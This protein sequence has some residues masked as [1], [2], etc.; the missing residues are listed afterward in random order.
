VSIAGNNGAEIWMLPFPGGAKAR[1]KPH[2]VLPS[3]LSS[4][5]PAIS[6]M[7]DNRH[8]VLSFAAPSRA[9]QLWMSDTAGGSVV[10][11]TSG[12]SPVSHPAV[13]P[14]GMKIACE[15]IMGNSDI[16]QLPVDGGM[17][18]PLLA[19]GSDESAAVWSRQAR[20]AAPQFAYVTSRNGRPE[21]W[22]RS[23]QEGW[24]RPVVTQQDFQDD[25][26]GF[27]SLAL[28]PDGER[29]AYMRTSN[30]RLATI[31][32]SPAG[33]GQPLQ[34]SSNDEFA[35]GPTWSPDGDWIAYSSSKRG[36][37]KLAAG[38]GQAPTQI[39]P[40][41][42]MYAAQSS[43]D[44][45]WI[46]CP[47][48]G[49]TSLISPDGKTSRTV[50][51]R[52]AMVTWSRDS[53]TLYT[54]GQDDKQKWLLTSIPVS[55]GTEKTIAEMGPENSFWAD[56]NNSSMISLSPD[57]KSIAATNTQSKSDVWLLEGFP[58]PGSWLRRLFWL[59]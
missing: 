54:L 53:K 13:S 5:A 27:F 34:L 8:M 7:P 59:R 16:V 20:N 4:Y 42:C 9:S 50:G 40:T 33:G 48:R 24:E 15:H 52:S 22:L 3:S 29:L 18:R 31:W 6:W 1:G 26:A 14:D 11:I 17:M 38:S 55:S 10:P 57:E 49:H 36:L 46:A 32:I 35:F 56:F 12:E 25:N 28:S 19:T 43:P 21:I 51:S 58:Q 37:V 41:A 30:K 47:D 45:Q 44:G 2:R 23:A 39:R